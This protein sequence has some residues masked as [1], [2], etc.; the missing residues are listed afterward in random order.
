[1]ARCGWAPWSCGILCPRPPPALMTQWGLPIWLERAHHCSTRNG[2][3]LIA[4]PAFVYHALSP[5]ACAGSAGGQTGPTRLVVCGGTSHAK[6]AIDG[7]GGCLSRPLC[8]VACVG[9]PVAAR[10]RSQHATLGR[11]RKQPTRSP[12]C[13]RACRLLP[14]WCC[15]WAGAGHVWG[16][17]RPGRPPGHAGH[18]ERGHEQPHDAVSAQQP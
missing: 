6:V 18:A 12:S 7:P 17:A 14:G 5:R 2:I 16:G 3:S 15:C 13:T 9:P 4:A 10:G 11:L 1:M 8:C